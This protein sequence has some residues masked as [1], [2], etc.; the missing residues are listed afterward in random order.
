MQV[1]RKFYT[2]V[3]RDPDNPLN[4]A[5]IRN[6]AKQQF[7]MEEYDVVHESRNHTWK[8][9]KEYGILHWMYPT[10]AHMNEGNHAGNVCLLL[11]YLFA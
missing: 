2:E 11:D 1:W 4:C 9:T 7:Y 10:T 8:N 3:H 6:R 5:Q